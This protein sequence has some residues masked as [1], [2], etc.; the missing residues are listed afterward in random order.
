MI[1][2]NHKKHQL[3]LFD[4]L[5]NEYICTKCNQL[6]WYQDYDSKNYNDSLK[7]MKYLKCIDLK[8]K[9]DNEMWGDLDSLNC[10]ELIIKNIIE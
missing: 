10:D 3:V 6:I 7:E 4:E 1:N 2:L 8:N 5:L 9:I